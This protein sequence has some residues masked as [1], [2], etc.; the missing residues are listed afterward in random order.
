MIWLKWARSQTSTSI[1]HLGEIGGA[2]QH[3]EV[4]D[5]AV[6]LADDLGDLRQRAGLVG[7]GHADQGRKALGI[8]GVDVPGDVD[9]ALVL[10]A[11]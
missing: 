5:V 9:P 8:L 10:V 1:T 4:V 2:A 11:P 6:G 7:R 3:L